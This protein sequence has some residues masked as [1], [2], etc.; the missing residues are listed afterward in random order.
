[1]PIYKL[2]LIIINI[3]YRMLPTAF[4]YEDLPKNLSVGGGG[5]GDIPFSQLHNVLVQRFTENR[6]FTMICKTLLKIHILQ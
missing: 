6:Y 3:T 2:F 1:M 4:L 5:D